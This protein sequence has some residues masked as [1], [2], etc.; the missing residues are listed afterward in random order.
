LT[1]AHVSEFARYDRPSAWEGASTSWEDFRESLLRRGFPELREKFEGKLWAPIRLKPGARRATDSVLEI[2]ACVLDID[3]ATE[4]DVADVLEALSADGI[5]WLAHTSYSHTPPEDCRWRVIVPLV[6]PILGRSWSPLWRAA[7]QRYAPQQADPQCKDVARQYFWPYVAPGQRGE[8]LWGRG[9]PLDPS[10]LGSV[11][12]LVA[13]S[14]SDRQIS[15]ELLTTLAGR[16]RRLK[17][18]EAADLGIRLSAAMQGEAFAKPGER[19]TILM[20]LCGRIV[21]AFP[22]CDPASVA[23]CF[24]TSIDRMRI[25][26]P[27][28]PGVEAIVDKITRWKKYRADNTLASAAKT[29]TERTQRMRQAFGDG[30]STEYSP[31]EIAGL[32]ASI[33]VPAD[34]L[35]RY[36]I[37]QAGSAYYVLGPDGRFVFANRESLPSVARVTLAPSPVHAVEFPALLNQHLTP[38]QRVVKSLPAQKATLDLAAHTLTLPCCRRRELAPAYDAQINEWLTLLGGDTVLDWLSLVTRI[39]HPAP[40]LV[41]LGA[42]GAGK[43]ALGVGVSRIWTTSG[44][45][46]IDTLFDAFNSRLEACPLVLADENLPTDFRGNV[47]TEELRKIIQQT[48]RMSN[49]KHR[50]PV[51]LRGACRMIIAANG[52]AILDMR[53][54]LTQ[55]DIRAIAE[56]F[57]AI[58]VTQAPADFLESIGGRDFIED[59]W[60]QGDGIAK[61]ALWLVE[62]RELKRE[63]RFGIVSKDNLAD[64]I[65]VRTGLRSLVAEWCVKCL[66]D[67]AQRI[68]ADLSSACQIRDGLLLLHVSALTE[69]WRSYQSDFAPKLAQAAQAL[70]G[71]SMGTIELD[72]TELNVIDTKKLETWAREHSYCHPSKIEQALTP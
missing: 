67:G 63:G 69:N 42:G 47:R 21:A 65:S 58:D 54:H 56:R 13:E 36:W 18:P 46:S 32:A 16:W 50:E 4:A 43:S 15:P 6:E 10:S 61:H 23:D 48:S 1:V 14:R 41:L 72:G 44:P 33:G 66:L 27:S 39:E 20:S 62:N 40:A 11:P 17:E 38:V 31:D 49:A 45:T 19:D 5:E 37:V 55:A 26:D 7:V 71:I 34:L 30:R 51:E 68:T 8:F 3:H 53:Q 29:Q 22:D 64:R 52:P 57:L 12:V 35:D 28:G 9:K 2:S 25:E 59:H 60:I 24:S 70:A